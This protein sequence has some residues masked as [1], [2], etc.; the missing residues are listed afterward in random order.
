M[1]KPKCRVCGARHYSHEA[2]RFPE[3]EKEGPQ[4]DSRVTPPVGGERPDEV[5][6]E[7]ASSVLATGGEQDQG[8]GGKAR[9]RDKWREE[10][11]ERYRAYMRDYM[12]RRR[13]ES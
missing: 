7:A 4:V 9:R 8:G 3:T 10:D 11:P 6:S 5:A 12:A 2:H 1:E 13:R